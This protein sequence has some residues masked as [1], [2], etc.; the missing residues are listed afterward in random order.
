MMSAL[1]SLLATLCRSGRSALAA[2]MSFLVR[3]DVEP[4]N[5]PHSISKRVL[6]WWLLIFSFAATAIFALLALPI[7]LA[8]EVE[9]GEN[10][11]RVFDQ[12]VVTVIVVVVLLG[13][14]VE[15]MMFRGW[16]AGT[17]QAIFGV[18]VFLALFYGG[19]R[20]LQN[21]GFAEQA[22]IAAVAL[23]L[24]VLIQRIG[25]PARPTWYKALFPYLFWTQGIVFGGLHFANV[26]GSSYVLPILMTAPFVICGWLFGYA[27]TV[28][29][30]GGAWLLHSAYNLPAVLGTALIFKFA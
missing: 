15:E 21:P 30:F 23:M 27:R 1:A 12:S 6:F 29:G 26:A 5:G 16:L 11:R 22:G 19:G 18:L 9:P 17:Y 7:L 4:S 3:P 20:L 10:L 28:L 8:S 24:F 14:L 13:P 2:F 25:K